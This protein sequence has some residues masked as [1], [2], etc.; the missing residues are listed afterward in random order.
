MSRHDAARQ[1]VDSLL[2]RLGNDSV[3]TWP[4]RIR[5][6]YPSELDVMAEAAALRLEQRWGGWE[7]EP[8]ADDSVKHISVYAAAGPR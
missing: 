3:R 6:S 1:R 2:V 8:F 4:V 5:Y 7:R